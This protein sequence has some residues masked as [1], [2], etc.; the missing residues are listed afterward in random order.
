LLMSDHSLRNTNTIASRM[1]I[2]WSA[3]RIPRKGPDVGDAIV[4]DIEK[5]REVS[6]PTTE[7]EVKDLNL[8]ERLK[9]ACE[10]AWIKG[11]GL[12]AIQIGVPLRYA[13]FRWGLDD[14]ELLNPEIIAF[15]GVTK[16]K[17]E[18]CLSIP[19]NWVHVR[20]AS[21]I[22]Y[23]SAGKIQTAKEFKAHIIQHEVDHMDGILNIDKAEATSRS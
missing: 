14:F 16:L 11:T 20:R 3:P 19:D 1:R 8:F 2:R 21:K 13:W 7:G 17:R 18:A 4:T 10:D 15:K 5:L 22:R 23:V 12:A 6:K 9:T